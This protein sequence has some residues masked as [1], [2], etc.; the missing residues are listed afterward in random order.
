MTITGSAEKER[1]DL[2]HGC[3]GVS[4]DI[5][6]GIL[7][8]AP[9]VMSTWNT[10]VILKPSARA[11]SA[12][13]EKLSHLIFV[14]KKQD[15]ERVYDQIAEAWTIVHHMNVYVNERQ[16]AEGTFSPVSDNLYDLLIT[17][18]RVAEALVQIAE[19]K[20]KKQPQP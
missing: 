13:Y 15:L 11:T 5:P 1:N 19:G 20:K 18:P 8:V 4:D 7:W 10:S 16:R 17:A 12:D 14:Y 3:F 2:A 9:T 6:D